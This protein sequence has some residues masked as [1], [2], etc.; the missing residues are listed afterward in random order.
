MPSSGKNTKLSIYKS[1]SLPRFNSRQN[2]EQKYF[3]VSSK[4]RGVGW[5]GGGNTLRAKLPNFGSMSEKRQIKKITDF[6]AVHLL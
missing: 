6:C 4:E 5:G 3:D 2:V 1:I